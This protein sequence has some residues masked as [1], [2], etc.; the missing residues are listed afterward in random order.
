MFHVK[1]FNYSHHLK[2]TLCFSSPL[3]IYLASPP[4]STPLIKTYT[5]PLVMICLS[6]YSPSTFFHSVLPFPFFSLNQLTFLSNSLLPHTYIS[7]P[8]YPSTSRPH[9]HKFPQPEKA[10]IRMRPACWKVWERERRGQ[11]GLSRS[12]TFQHAP[13]SIKN[14]SPK[15]FSFI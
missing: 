7:S 12:H 13:P 14:F 4:S 9:P 2:F 5:Y 6:V 1:H 10:S 8:Y 15:K 11:T 3:L